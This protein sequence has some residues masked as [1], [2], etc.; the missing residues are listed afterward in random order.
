MPAVEDGVVDVA[1]CAILQGHGHLQDQDV[2]SHLD[3]I[4]QEKERKTSISASISHEPLT[5][6]RESFI[7]YLVS[8]QR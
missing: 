8:Y 5:M 1:F 7:L 4:T 6:R 2:L 3:D